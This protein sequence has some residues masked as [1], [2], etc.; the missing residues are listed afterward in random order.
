[1]SSW[2]IWVAIILLLD[3]GIGLWNAHWLS[4]LMPPRHILRIAIIEAAVA[5]ALLVWFF[6]RRY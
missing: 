4:R 1:M 2:P 6:L 3:A 5:I